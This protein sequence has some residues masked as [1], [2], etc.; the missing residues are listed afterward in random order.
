M[1]CYGKFRDSHFVKFFEGLKLDQMDQ[2]NLSLYSY[3]TRSPMNVR[4]IDDK[5]GELPDARANH[6]GGAPV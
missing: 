4:Q 2:V 5:A 6:D 3:H 1:Q